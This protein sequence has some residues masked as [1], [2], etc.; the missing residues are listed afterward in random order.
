VGVVA[1]KIFWGL[2]CIKC[3]HQGF[4]CNTATLDK[5]ISDLGLA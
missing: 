3:F 4:E 2:A 1:D 5:N